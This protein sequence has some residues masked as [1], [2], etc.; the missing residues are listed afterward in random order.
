MEMKIEILA[1]N[2]DTMP[3]IKKFRQLAEDQ[4]QESELIAADKLQK[5]YTR[6]ITRSMKPITP[7]FI[8]LH[9]WRNECHANGYVFIAHDGEK[10]RPKI[11]GWLMVHIDTFEPFPHTRNKPPITVAHVDYISTNHNSAGGIGKKIMSRLRHVMTNMGCDFIELMPLPAVVGF[12]EKLG[13]RLD[14]EAVDYYT[15]WL[16]NTR[17]EKRYTLSAYYNHLIEKMKRIAQEIEEAEVAEF[18]PIYAKF[19]EEEKEIYEAMQSQVDSTRIGM[20]MTYEESG[21]DME[22]VRKM[23]T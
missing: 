20:I 16:N 2:R 15:L 11:L 22:E 12:Y 3:R 7:D 13:Y 1:C 9:P 5:Q 18:K 14:F 17:E 23:L 6:R 4:Q 19:T 10:P 8:V 21:H